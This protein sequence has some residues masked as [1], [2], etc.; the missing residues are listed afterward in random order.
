MRKLVRTKPS[1]LQSGAPLIA[2]SFSNWE[3]R[4]MIPILDYCESIDANKPDPLSVLKKQGKIKDDIE[5]EEELNEK[6]K[7]LLQRVKD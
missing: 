5:K 1:Q 4:E 2:G 6:Q 3:A 7:G